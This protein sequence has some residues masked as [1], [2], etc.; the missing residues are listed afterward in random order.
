MAILTPRNYHVSPC[1]FVFDKF[2]VNLI[3]GVRVSLVEFQE[4]I[5]VVVETHGAIH[6]SEK[7]ILIGFR[8][9]S[10]KTDGVDGTGIG[11]HRFDATAFY[12]VP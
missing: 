1:L 7:H 3:A 8:C 11:H 4:V 2:G 12:H 6:A 9:H 5:L 10:A